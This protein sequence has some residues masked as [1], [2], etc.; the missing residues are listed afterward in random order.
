MGVSTFSRSP[1][2][3]A[4]CRACPGSVQRG[5]WAFRTPGQA[6]WGQHHGAVAGLKLTE[7]ETEKPSPAGAGRRGLCLASVALLSEGKMKSL[8]GRASRRTA[9]LAGHRGGH[10]GGDTKMRPLEGHLLSSGPL[11]QPS[12][13]L[14]WGGNVSRS[15]ERG[16]QTGRGGAVGH[17]APSGAGRRLVTDSI[18]LG[19]RC[20]GGRWWELRPFSPG[21]YPGLTKG[22]CWSGTGCTL[23]PGT[24]H[25]DGRG[26]WGPR[27]RRPSLTWV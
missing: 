2:V 17:G 8:G 25:G 23:Q 12:L 26:G 13:T 1:S 20:V 18:S 16:K 9:H 6:A 5:S 19:S 14:G 24:V 11:Q 21:Q 3:C 22:Q 7:M 27:L 15:G 4:A 10:R